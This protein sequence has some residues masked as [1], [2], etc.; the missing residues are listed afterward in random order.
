MTGLLLPTAGLKLSE[1]YQVD[2]TSTRWRGS[3]LSLKEET[4][5]TPSSGVY[6]EDPWDTGN[7]R[8]RLNGRDSKRQTQFGTRQRLQEPCGSQGVVPLH[9]YRPIQKNMFNRNKEQPQR[10]T[11][12]VNQKELAT[13]RGLLTSRTTQ[14]AAQWRL[15]TQFQLRVR[16]VPAST[17]NCHS[18]EMSTH[19]PALRGQQTV[20]RC[21]AKAGSRKQGPELVP[22]VLS[23]HNN[24][25]WHVLSAVLGAVFTTGDMRI[26]G[27]SLDFC[28]LGI[29]W[30]ATKERRQEL[31]GS[32]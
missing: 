22:P 32:G 7:Q 13:F 18:P 5:G 30:K 29:G 26:N 27:Q 9:S 19:F 8:I 23:G 4:S 17:L 12:A 14:V 28:S 16:L 3:T 31:P 10:H 21:R 24:S 6:C 15:G 20:A 2:F 1:L 11:K 25:I